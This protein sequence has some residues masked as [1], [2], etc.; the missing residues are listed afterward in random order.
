MRKPTGNTEYGGFLVLQLLLED[1]YGVP[2]DELMQREVFGV[3]PT[4]F[5]PV[6]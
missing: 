5:M 3:W 1:S 2:L 4:V 6:S